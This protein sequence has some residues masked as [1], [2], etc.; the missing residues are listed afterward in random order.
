MPASKRSP[1]L[2]PGAHQQAAQ[3]AENSSRRA[4]LRAARA[5]SRAA[6]HQLDPWRFLCTGK[7]LRS[8]E[9]GSLAGAGIKFKAVSFCSN[10]HPE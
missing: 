1:H 3:A 8:R 6:C 4:V 10:S 9:S 2:A 5:R 7:Y